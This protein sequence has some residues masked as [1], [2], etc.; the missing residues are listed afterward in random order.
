M[1]TKS[2][3]SWAAVVAAIFVFVIWGGDY[4]PV[5][6]GQVSRANAD[7]AAVSHENGRRLD[8]V[9]EALGGFATKA[10]LAEA[11]N[12]SEQRGLETA[13]IWANGLFAT[14]SDV[15]AL[16]KKAE[17]DVA[18][19]VADAAAAKKLTTETRWLVR[20]VVG[21][22]RIPEPATAVADGPLPVGV[23]RQGS[24]VL[25]LGADGAITL[26]G[27]RRAAA[28]A[29]EWERQRA[30]THVAVAAPTGATDA[31]DATDVIPLVT[32]AVPLAAVPPLVVPPSAAA[33]AANDSTESESV[34]TQCVIPGRFTVSPQAVATGENLK[35]FCIRHRGK[36]LSSP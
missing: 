3:L 30:A 24:R 31:T 2:I 21:D 7:Q 28:A 4:R 6:R 26:C 13:Q 15:G 29:A 23:A 35:D 9:E 11:I 19:A 20:A 34:C 16:Q 33:A 27:P 14:K 18:G 25:C 5:T 12:T 22:L 10:D 17:A 36:C 1:S 8:V 32:T